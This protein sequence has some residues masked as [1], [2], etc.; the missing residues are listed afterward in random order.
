MSNYQRS[1]IMVLY[2]REPI[3]YK[4]GNMNSRVH[5]KGDRYSRNHPSGKKT[6]FDCPASRNRIIPT[7]FRN[8]LDSFQEPRSYVSQNLL[9]T[10]YTLMVSRSTIVNIYLNP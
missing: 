7:Q 4:R 9:V 1:W 3:A 8:L 10:I 5:T 6:G 2:Y